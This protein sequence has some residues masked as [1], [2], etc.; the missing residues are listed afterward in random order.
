[1]KKLLNRARAKVVRECSRISVLARMLTSS[2]KL[3]E[4]T[5]ALASL[6]KLSPD[7]GGSC[8]TDNGFEYEERSLVLSVIIPAYN[9]EKCIINCLESVLQQRISLPYE[10]IV[11]DDGSTDSTALLLKKYE[12]D[13][14]VSILHQRNQGLSAA[15]NKGL[16]C[17]KG[18][19]LCFVDSDDELPEGALEVLL[20]T[21]LNKQAKLVIGSYDK[22]LRDGPIQYTRRLKDEKA[23]SRSLPGFAH[24]RVIHYTVLQNLKFPEGYWYEDTIMSQIVHPMCSD[25]AYTVSAVCYKYYSNEA[26]ISTISKGNKKSL[27]SL[28]ITMRLLN[29]RKLFGL[30]TTQDSYECFLSMVGLTYHRTKY[31]GAE[32][33]RCVFVVQ[34]M[35]F[36]RYY[37][38][39]EVTSNRKKERIQRALRIN[40]FRKYIL[41][42]ELAR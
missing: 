34:R 36:E 32:V 9:V 27:D 14:R 3:P 4:A 21:A 22:C 17:S 20:T 15:R 19:Y 10:L 30:V 18:Q 41:A 5:E 26:G 40:D 29:E 31:L 7:L 1:M 35:L 37:E 13:P 11:V 33:A 2:G 25:A 8:W 23:Q 39:C 24:G 38:N 6:Q 12:Q 28:W 42:C 16:A